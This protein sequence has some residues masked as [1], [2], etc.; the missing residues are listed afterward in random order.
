[1]SKKD[2]NQN[3]SQR[4]LLTFAVAA[5][6]QERFIKEAVEGAFSQTYSPL[7]II[8]SDDCSEDRTFE[9]IKE[10]AAAYRGP[11][12]VITNRN[13]V[14]K[15]IGGHINRI[16]E[17]SKG[18]LIAGAAGDDIAL[19]CRVESAYRAWEGSG[20]KATSI[21]CD[22]TQIDEFGKPIEQIY[23]TDDQ[24]RDGQCLHQPVTPLEYVRT[25]KPIVF[26]CT[27]TFARSLFERFGRLED[28]VIHEDNAIAFRSI[29]AGAIYYV[30][31][32]LM[33]YRLH[34]NN[35]YVRSNSN[36]PMDLA[37]LER[38]ERRVLQDFRNRERMFRGFLLDLETAKK[39][40][41]I[42]ALECE[43]VATE[44]RRMRQRFTMKRE[45]LESGLLTKCRIFSQLW[46]Q[47]LDKKEF[48]M[49]GR[50]LLP[51]GLLLRLRLA[52]S[53][54]PFGRKGIA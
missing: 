21:Y 2:Q 4:P 3:A 6:N 20:R 37:S 12:R 5:F 50:R 27:H 25:L 51:Q 32:P 54:A 43:A 18:E 48:S 47:G 30:K 39:Q 34:G 14:R 13:P 36:R 19:P 7:E 23:K 41:V 49:L 1:M 10:L 40:D 26:G 16:I 11:H 45:F 52:R 24:V 28:E 46:R 22:F 31:E 9:I 44:A 29:L 38:Q 33:K 35:V 17:L 53:Y 42:A 15:S 8:L